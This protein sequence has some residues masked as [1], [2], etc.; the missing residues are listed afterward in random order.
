ME[1][2]EQTQGLLM[3]NTTTNSKL[4]FFIFYIFC[5]LFCCWFSLV[6]RFCLPVLSV[7]VYVVF[8]CACANFQTAGRRSHFRPTY[9]FSFL[10]KVIII[11]TN[12][13]KD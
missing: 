8:V 12:L 5:Y 7:R 10:E 9:H 6:W 13:K 4:L 3:M 11:L 2:A 1:E